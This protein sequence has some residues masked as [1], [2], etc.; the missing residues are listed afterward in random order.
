MLRAKQLYEFMANFRYA[1]V[2]LIEIYLSFRIFVNILDSF[3][4]SPSET[5]TRIQLSAG[6]FVEN[7]SYRDV[8]F[9]QDDGVHTIPMGYH[10]RMI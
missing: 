10:Y 8:L 2:C 6:F 4:S 7:V 5:K 3:K 9:S 1:R